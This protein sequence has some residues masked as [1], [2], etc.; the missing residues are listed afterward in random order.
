MFSYLLV[1]ERADISESIKLFVREKL[2][3]FGH[4]ELELMTIDEL[5]NID[6]QGWVISIWKR[7]QVT[8]PFLMKQEGQ[9]TSH[10]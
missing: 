8:S 4:G 10:A 5:D 6:V 2:V 3:H 1:E 9:R 7:N